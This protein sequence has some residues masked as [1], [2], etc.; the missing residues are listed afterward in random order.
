LIRDLGASDRV[1]PNR[2]PTEWLGACHAFR[3]PGWRRP[4]A[5]CPE[6][7]EPARTYALALSSNFEPSWGVGMG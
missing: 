1:D 3:H 6:G 4:R 5:L 7:F 2:D